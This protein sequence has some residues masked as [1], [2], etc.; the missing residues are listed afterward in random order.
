MKLSN[1][2]TWELIEILN[3]LCEPNDFDFA[4]QQLRDF[5]AKYGFAESDN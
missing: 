4:Y 5:I 1:E 2:Q 3:L